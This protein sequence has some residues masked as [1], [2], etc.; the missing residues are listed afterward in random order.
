MS[1]DGERFGDYEILEPI[2]AGGMGTVHRAVQHPLGREV[3][4]KRL[5]PG[6]GSLHELEMQA[7]F[8]REMKIAAMLRHPNVVTL[9]DA[10]SIEDVPYLAM[11]LIEGETLQALLERME[12]RT[13]EEACT[14]L[15]GIA[16]GLAFLHEHG[17]LHR[18]LKPSNVMIS[19]EGVPR[20]IDFGLARVH[21]DTALTQEG[22]ALGTVEYMAPELFQDGAW[23]V[24]SDIW[25]LGQIHYR[26]LTNRPPFVRGAPAVMAQRICQDPIEAPSRIDPDIPGP[27]S[28]LVM[29][30]LERVAERRPPSCRNVIELTERIM[31]GAGIAPV[32]STVKARRTVGD[33]MPVTS[34]TPRSGKGRAGWIFVAVALLG[35]FCISLIAF[36]VSVKRTHPAGEAA[37]PH[38][39]ALPGPPAPVSPLP[40]RAAAATPSSTAPFLF[41]REAARH[42]TELAADGR[43]GR[44]AAR[45]LSRRSP[46]D[47]GPEPGSWIHWIRLGRWLERGEGPPPVSPRA[48]SGRMILEEEMFLSGE[49]GKAERDPTAARDRIEARAAL[50]LLEVSPA[51]GRCWVLLGHT[52]ERTGQLAE[53]DRVYATGLDRRIGGEFTS[54][55]AYE[56]FVRAM[57]RVPG[58]DPGRDWGS[59]LETYPP[60]QTDAWAGLLGALGSEDPEKAEHVLEVTSFD[61]RLREEAL[62]HRIA[63]VWRRRSDP[64]RASTLSRQA[65]RELPSSRRLLSQETELSLHQGMAPGGLG[66]RP[67]P[68][69]PLEIRQLRYCLGASEV[70]YLLPEID[71]GPPSTSAERALEIQQL[72]LDGE[73]E[74]VAQLLD[75][76]T[77]GIYEPGRTPEPLMDASLDLAGARSTPAGAEFS[78]RNLLLGAIPFPALW[79]R[80]TGPMSVG[81]AATAMESWLQDAGRRWPGAGW[82]EVTRSLWLSRR[83]EITAGIEALSKLETADRTPDV[84]AWVRAEVLM[85]AVWMSLLRRKPIPSL[86]GPAGPELAPFDACWNELRQGKVASSAKHLEPLLGAPAAGPV[87]HLVLLWN[88]A[89]QGK[90]GVLAQVRERVTISLRAMHLGRWLEEEALALERGDGLY[91]P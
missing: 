72:L 4:L 9:L 28:A 85:R 29:Q 35:A 12:P 70:R 19:P 45:E 88:A 22:T 33:V 78:V 3:A 11:E 63:L 64:G 91:A 50:R 82:V 18:D 26:L 46:L 80:A 1:L 41:W 39:A 17:I 36:K 67:I 10:G 65:I 14:L 8:F 48:T 69:Q 30:M 44:R 27:V 81:Q 71:P 87:P 76:A 59:L 62:F 84:P 56:C 21:G 25:S 7:R 38:G 6:R 2:G 32:D 53:A 13:W 68:L 66:E 75:A 31:S 40:E 16:A 42:E 89:Y 77:R 15:L 24:A 90:P 61:P 34:T 57:L 5:L 20:L 43:E 49:S 83:G 86:P 37:T 58:H 73:V 79:Y 74:K 52:L 47:I 55:L 60:G 51:D 23:T 54:R